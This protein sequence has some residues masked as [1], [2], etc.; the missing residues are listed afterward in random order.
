VYTGFFRGTETDE[1]IKLYFYDFVNLGSFTI[2]KFQTFD[3]KNIETSKKYNI[4]KLESSRPPESPPPPVCTSTQA[5]LTKLKILNNERLVRRAEGF[6]GREI[7]CVYETA[8]LKLMDDNNKIVFS[9]N[10]G[11]SFVSCFPFV[12]SLASILAARF[13]TFVVFLFTFNPI[14]V[15]NPSVFVTLVVNLSTL[16]C[17]F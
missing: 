8:K 17:S 11:M 14:F 9:E 13:A 15:V 12:V 3:V 16:S 5:I 10:Y 7:F 6:C 1:P 2:F 4:V